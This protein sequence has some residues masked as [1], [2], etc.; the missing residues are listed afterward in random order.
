MSIEAFYVPLGY[1]NRIV[2]RPWFDHEDERRKQELSHN[3]KKHTSETIRA[4]IFGIAKRAQTSHQ[5]RFQRL[6][7]L[8]SIPMRFMILPP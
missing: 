7:S 2:D 8:P 4:V 6:L 3:Q 1:R 5:Q